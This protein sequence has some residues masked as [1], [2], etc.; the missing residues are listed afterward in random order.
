ML[1]YAYPYPQGR[2]TNA[3]L[4][5]DDVE[6]AFAD[7]VAGLA[8]KARQSVKEALTAATQGTPGARHPLL[9]DYAAA[10]SALGGDAAWARVPEGAR[11]D[12][13]RAAA[14]ALMGVGGGG[15]GGGSRD[16]HGGGGG[17]GGRDVY[18]G[19]GGGGRDVSGGV[20]AG[21]FGGGGRDVHGGGSGGGGGR[22]V[23]GAGGG[24]ERERQP[25][26]RGNRSRS[27]DRDKRPR[28]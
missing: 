22:D 17:G 6:R 18:S 13:W 27:R 3:L 12:V 16:V 24:R 20:G 21:G 5:R 28:R 14:D 7:H 15:A 26:E 1:S 8:E 11:R 23:Y 10:D 4:E 25:A 9:L 2:A 19:A